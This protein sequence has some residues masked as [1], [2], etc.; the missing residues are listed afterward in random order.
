MRPCEML[1]IEYGMY[2]KKYF[3]NVAIVYIISAI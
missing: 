1:C 3:T 2:N